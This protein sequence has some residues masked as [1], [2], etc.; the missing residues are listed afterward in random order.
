MGPGLK[1]ST[2][3]GT[4]DLVDTIAEHEPPVVR[5]QTDLGLLEEIARASQEAQ[6]QM[7]SVQNGTQ[8]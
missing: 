1:E 2:A 7:A 4:D 3:V 8:P 5:R 6:I